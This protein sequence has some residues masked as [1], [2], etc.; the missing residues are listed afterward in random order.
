MGATDDEMARSR[1]CKLMKDRPRINHDIIDR[2]SDA[3]NW[4]CITLLAQVVGWTVA[5]LWR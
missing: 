5:L 4:A 3:F 1:F 2:R